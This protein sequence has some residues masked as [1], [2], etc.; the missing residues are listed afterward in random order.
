[1]NVRDWIH[2]EII[3]AVSL[4]CRLRKTGLFTI[5]AATVRDARNLEKY[6]LHFV[7]LGK[8]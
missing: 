1:M 2:V 6:E 4:W 7:W 8:L 3:G 5:S